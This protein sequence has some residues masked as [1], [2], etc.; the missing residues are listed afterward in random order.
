MAQQPLPEW[1]TY[2]PRGPQERYA[3]SKA[4]IEYRALQR[5]MGWA[6]PLPGDRSINEVKAEWLGQKEKEHNGDAHVCNILCPYNE[7]SGYF[8]PKD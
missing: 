4:D 3:V 5:R 1:A 7:R 6:P 8:P 2:R